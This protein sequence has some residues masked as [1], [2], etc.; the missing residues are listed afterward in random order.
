MKQT[1]PRV[2]IAGLWHET[3]GFAPM[4]TDLAAFRAYQWAE[5]VEMVTR[6]RGTNTE[7]G[8]MV[9]GAERAGLE[10]VPALFAGAIPSGRVTAGALEILIRRIEDT[11][12]EAKPLDGVLLALHGAM[13]ADGADE[14]DAEVVRR[15][16]SLVGPEV[17]IVV[18]FDLHANLSRA[19]VEA[20]DQLVGYDTFP[21][22]DMSARGDDCLLY[23]SP[24]PRDRSLSRMP[25]SA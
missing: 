21:H 22:T 5:G 2:L 15:V 3:N 16:R 23:T 13:I 12:R 19:L 8:G 7:I 10:L 9:A 25:S 14:A 4:V 11:A 20:A 6:Y 18:T 24:S 1:P 17:P